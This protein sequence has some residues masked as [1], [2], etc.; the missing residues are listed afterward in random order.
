[1]VRPGGSRARRDFGGA[2]DRRALRP[3]HRD[4]LEFVSAGR[5]FSA[6][7]TSVRKL[8]WDSM[9]PNFFFIA[10]PALLEGFPRATSR[11]FTH[12]PATLC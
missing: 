2:L 8:E 7:V 12:R 9:R 3:P 10:T 5:S 11:A 4:K 6:P 1:V